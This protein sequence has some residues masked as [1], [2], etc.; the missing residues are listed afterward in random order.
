MVGDSKDPQSTGTTPNMSEGEDTDGEHHAA[1]TA[2]EHRLYEDK[3]RH[4]YW[5]RWGPYLSERQWATV[6]EDYSPNGDAWSY[7]PYEHGQS[8]AYRWGEDGI[9]GFSD[10][11]ALQCVS[12]AFWNEKDD[13]LKERLFGVTGPEGN[14]GEDVK[15]EYFYLDNTPTHSYM[16]YQYKYPQKQFPYAELRQVNGER[17]RHEREYELVDT[18]IFEENRYWDIF[19]ETAK[20][21]ENPN[22][23][24]FKIVAYNRGPEP[25]TLDILP[26]VFFRNTWSWNDPDAGPKPFLHRWGRDPKVVKTFHHKLGQYYYQFEGNPELLFTEN[27]SNKKKLWGEDQENESKYV[28][29]AFHEYICEK[30]S[31]SVNPDGAG[32][33]MAA[34]YHFEDVPAGE[35]V[36]IRIRMS[37]ERPQPGKPPHWEEL[38]DRIDSRVE[39]ADE[40]YYKVTPLP[41]E[42]E[43]QNIQRQAFAGMLWNKQYFCFIWGPWALGDPHSAMPPPPERI[44]IR[45]E[46]WRHLHIDDV[47]SM[48]DKWEYPFFAA[49]DTAF[50]CIPLAMIDPEYAKK[51]LDLLCRE[52]YMHPNGQVPAYE[53]NFSDVNPPVHAWATFRVFKIERRMYGKGDLL[54]LER[55]F[56]KLL[57]NFTWWV[58]QK[59]LNGHNVFEGGFLGMDNIGLFNRSEALPTGGVLE[60]ADGTGWMAFYC[61]QM[62]SIALELSRTRIVYEDIA[63]KFFEHFL[64][65]ADAMTY[66]SKSTVVDDDDSGLWDEKDGFYY[67]KISFGYHSHLRLPVRSLV[68][69][70]PLFATLSIESDALARFPKF[71]KRVEWFIRH[72]PEIASRNIASLRERGQNDRL[73]LALV[74]KDRL[75]RILSRML[76]S[77]EFLSDY[78]I[79]S[80]SK[81]HK[82]HPYSM[83][84]NGGTWVVDYEPGEST[85]G[86][87]GGN[88]N[89]RGPIW[90]PTNF[91]LIESMQRL[92]L[93]Y[94]KSFKTEL[95]SGS[96]N[97]VNLARVAE[98]LQ[99]RLINLFL[100]DGN[101]R[102]PYNGANDLHDFDPHF[103]EGI[104]FYEYFDPD[105][106][107]GLGS[108]HQNG[109]TGLVAKLIQDTGMSL[110]YP[111]SFSDN[112]KEAA[113]EFFD[114]TWDSRPRTYRE[115]HGHR[116]RKP[117]LS[118]SNSTHRIITNIGDMLEKYAVSEDGVDE[119]I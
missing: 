79:R 38:E 10:T 87:F 22:D 17:S 89:W 118:R 80:M 8:R 43:L 75:Q 13:F 105:S 36:T 18:G 20:S 56:Q 7:F 48:P 15:E 65:I 110:N 98:S 111:K 74:N 49:W 82:D 59:D 67:D 76:D 100:R 26:H 28:K 63:S 91:L 69:L 60:Q 78:G 107:R 30:K 42:E 108:K 23:I 41:L 72:R 4:K 88:S 6:R 54:F 114:D 53:W 24:V 52:W 35:S 5:K 33:K 46:A 85:S 12:F 45:N 84:V 11:H 40:F 99:H 44:K 95:P 94:G 92:F 119:T 104:S 116:R 115:S 58:N 16:N 34:H 50:H 47:L 112:P 66:N 70:I 71:A 31:G 21:S 90:F 64:L 3:I 83:E 73:L 117:T 55:V 25:A 19:I 39:D 97:Y 29:D 1:L 96:G 102:R 101:K 9:A 77:N 57:L 109:W 27:N 113:K 106:G 62:L 103:D 68:G 93:F 81:H 14:H 61:L 86:M 51:Q 2:E 32:T 37:T